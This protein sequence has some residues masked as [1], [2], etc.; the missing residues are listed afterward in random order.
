MTMMNNK[1]FFGL[2]LLT[3]VSFTLCFLLD[4]YSLLVFTLCVLTVLVGVGL[5][6]LMGMSGQISFGHI[7][8]YAIG[9]YVSA[10]LLINEV[11]FVFAI[12]IAAFVSGFVGILLAIPAL[13]VSGPYLA[14]ITIAFAFAVHHGLMEWRGLTGGANGLMGIPMPT[15][16]DI[17]P[18]QLLALAA[19]FLMCISLFAYAL[20]YNSGWGK[21]M[22]AVKASPIAARSLG[23]NPIQTKTA[24]FAISAWF[25][26]LAGAIIP[27]LMMYISPSTFPFSQSILFV[28]VVIIGGTGTLWG[29]V[30]GAI[31]VV[32]LPEMLSPLAE[33]RLLI[34]AAL[35]LSVLWGAPRGLFGEL[36]RRFAKTQIEL[37][38][39]LV[40]QQLLLQ[41][42]DSASNAITGLKVDNI[43][44]QFGG[45]KAAQSVSFDASLG[46]VT[47]IIGPNGAGKTTVLNMISGFYQPDQGCIELGEQLAGKNAYQIARSGIARTYQ[48]SQLF[49]DMSVLENLLSAMQQGYMG[50]PFVSQKTGQKE[51]ALNLLALVG[52]S[53]S[54][55]TPSQDLPH[56]DR[57]LVE[58]ARAL[59][60]RPWVL[61]LDEPA[62]GLSRQDTDKL[63]ALLR[64]IAS[65]GIAV[66]LV[67]HDMPLVMEVSDQ[68]LVLDAG[69]PIAQG[70]PNIIRQDKTV[71]EAY[72]GGTDYQAQPRK[73]PWKGNKDAVLF[74]KKLSV[75]YGAAPVVH[76]VDIV[77]YPGELVAIL[78]A[79]GAGKSSILQALAGLKRPISGHIGL[80]DEYINELSANEIAH[81]G[82]ALVPEGRQLF[83]NLSVRDNLLMGAYSRTDIVDEN[84]EINEI[85]NRFPRLKDRIDSEAGLLSGG[86]QQMVAVG[87]ALMAKPKVLL[88]DEPSLGL[89]PAMIGELYDALA[90]LRDDGVTILLVDQMANLALQVADRGY[91]LETGRIV[92]SANAK[93]LLANPELEQAYMGGS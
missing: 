18:N 56:V 74:C 76:D 11:P 16:G 30:F 69:K 90:T 31:I 87:R 23:F 2:G 50:T 17:D 43:G 22:R 26:G 73:S 19:S 79:N 6:I 36:Q 51:L 62:A 9:A 81:R 48:T 37:P 28:L 39:K 54:I 84:A 46:N 58:I 66:I 12:I 72:L 49:D 64:V 42:Y 25:T 71:I 8:F 13:R 67:E 91:V 47:S 7:A 3:L 45:V 89:A 82:L 77:V 40:N 60:T 20:L 70:A 24:A 85:L 41:F 86:E 44:I 15:L 32:V 61:L 80:Q 75:D 57:R 88:L 4:S 68:I 78:G 21:S 29:P 83:T 27:P 63:S 53:G 5:N 14:M 92:K 38:P 35:L 10:L 1:S 93:E 65:Y 55:H 52:Y 33:Y 34:F 59:A